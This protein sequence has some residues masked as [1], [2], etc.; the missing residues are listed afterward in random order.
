MGAATLD[1]IANHA[2]AEEKDSFTAAYLT[3]RAALYGY[4][5]RL[6]PEDADAEDLTVVV[7]EKALRAWDRRPPASELR[8]WLFRIATNVCLDELRRRAR[9]QR[10]PW[11]IIRRL[12]QPAA[13]PSG[14]PEAEVMRR[15]TAS[16]VR[17]ALARL[18]PRDR[19]ALI[20]R[21]YHGLSVEE[22]GRALSISTAAAKITLFRARERLRTAYL[23][24]GGELPRDYWSTRARPSAD[25]RAGPAPPDQAET[26]E[27]EIPHE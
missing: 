19:A 16:L 8:A 23:D 4:V 25:G 27:S 1:Q 5:R 26:S 6:V 9:A 13:D 7:F 24:L 11:A 18:S 3:Y 14:N 2:D 12:L 10:Q 21:E 20:L 17:L 15:E 22:V